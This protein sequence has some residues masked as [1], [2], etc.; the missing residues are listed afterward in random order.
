MEMNSSFD[1]F[2]ASQVKYRYS[3]VFPIKDFL[4]VGVTAPVCPSVSG[5]HAVFCQALSSSCTV[6]QCAA[7]RCCSVEGWSCP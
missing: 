3:F 7:P 4:D 1:S 2:P 5:E 6:P